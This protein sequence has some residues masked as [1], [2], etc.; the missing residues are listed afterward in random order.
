M[1]ERELTGVLDDMGRS[2]PAFHAAYRWLLHRDPFEIDLTHPLV[3]A[4]RTAAGSTLSALP[5]EVAISYWADS[6][7]LAGA[8]IPTV[9]FGPGGAGAHEDVEWVDLDQVSAC[10]A[11]L[12]NLARAACA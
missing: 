8:G 12:L 1:I 3:G 5:D 4:M 11:S 7:F 9:L 6:A 2:D 10:A